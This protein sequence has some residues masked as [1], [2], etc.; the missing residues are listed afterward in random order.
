MTPP[1]SLVD[2]ILDRGGVVVL[3]LLI[4]WSLT[5]ARV[6]IPASFYELERRRND[7]LDSENEKLQQLV[8]KL[9]EENAGMKSEIGALR[10]QVE[11][12]KQEIHDLRKELADARKKT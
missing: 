11:A 4:L 1:Q 5:Y 2:R 7:A 10:E 6:L 12:M 9:T 3:L 8:L